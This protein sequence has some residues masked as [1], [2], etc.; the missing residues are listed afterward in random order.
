MGPNLGD[1]LMPTQQFSALPWQEQVTF[2]WDDDEIHF[3]VDRGST[4]RE[5]LVS[6]KKKKTINSYQ[7]KSSF[8]IVYIPLWGEKVIQKNGSSRNLQVIIFLI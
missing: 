7:S 4:A 1:C 8:D 6:L 3:V 5:I 2:P